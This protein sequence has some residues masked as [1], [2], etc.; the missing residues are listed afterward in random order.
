MSVA[1]E[2]I[3]YRSILKVQPGV[4]VDPLSE[5][6]RYSDGLSVKKEQWKHSAHISL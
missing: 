6:W 3:R 1:Y 4:S 5:K 2:E